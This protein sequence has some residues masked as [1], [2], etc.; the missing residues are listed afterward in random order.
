[1]NRIIFDKVRVTIESEQILVNL[2]PLVLED[3]VRKI[4]VIATRVI[5]GLTP[6]ESFLDEVF[7]G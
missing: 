1:L 7:P 6:M 5:K 2:W 3:I 4:N